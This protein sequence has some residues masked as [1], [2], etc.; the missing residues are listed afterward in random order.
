MKNPSATEVIAVFRSRVLWLAGLVVCL[1]GREEGPAFAQEAA[2]AFHLADGTS[3]PL[4]WDANRMIVRTTAE[5]SPSA[6]GEIARQ[7]LGRAMPLQTNSDDGRWFSLELGA[8][9]SREEWEARAAEWAADKTVAGV[10]PT[11]HDA[12]SG[13]RLT[14]TDEILVCRREG[15]T[16]EALSAVTAPLRLQLIER[17]RFDSRIVRL[18]AEDPSAPIRNPKSAIRNGQG[19]AALELANALF[20]SG[21]VEWAEPNF[22]IELRRAYFPNDP[23]FPQQWP[24]HNTGQT[25]GLPDADLD[26]AEAWDITRGSWGLTIAILDDGL[27]IAHPDLRGNVYVNTRE[28]PANGRDDDGNGYVDDVT[29]WDFYAN[30]NNPRPDGPEDWHSTPCAGMAAAIGDNGLGVTGVAPR[31]AILPCRI[32]GQFDST[33]SQIANAIHYASRTADILSLSW[34]A[35]PNNTISASLQN[36]AVEGRGGRG[37]LICAATGNEYQTTG[38]G[39]PANLSFVTA[40][41][42]STFRDVR[43]AYSNYAQG[44]G[45]FL[46]A[47]SSEPGALNGAYTLQAGGGYALFSGTSAATPEA[48]GVCALVLSVAPGLS[49]TQVADILARTADKIDPVVAGYDATGYS[50]AYGYGRVNAGRAVAEVAPDLSPAAFDFQPDVAARG[51][52]LALSGTVRNV[53]RGENASCWLEFWLSNSPTFATL[54]GLAC[55]SVRLPALAAGSEFRLEPVAANLLSSVADGFYRLGAVVDRLNEQIESNETNNVLSPSARILQVGGGSTN[56]DLRVEGF[57]FS[58]LEVTGG[59][60]IVLKG[61]VVN[62]GGQMS[63]PVWVEFWLSSKSNGG[64]LERVLCEWVGT[65]WLGPGEA[66]D[67]ATLSRTVFYPSQGM[68]SGRYRVGVVVDRPNG[69]VE[70]NENNNTVFRL[71]KWLT[72]GG[73]TEARAW[74]LYK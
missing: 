60:R 28:V 50:N 31:C 1:W 52:S 58:P 34:T 42:A 48:A 8:S 63:R 64:S 51:G 66:F 18:R 71:D 29:G 37:C 41:G 36:A 65:G 14:L 2:Y 25:G 6:V 3:V 27:D 21:A 67:L 56:V 39:Y 44:F 43:A 62:R 26:A 73:A 57:D 46:L 45:V 55:A 38:V 70:T 15:T 35:A 7:R 16:D 23:L 68:R 32:I 4:H 11:F 19:F 9:L 13:H 54:D 47:P 40:I 61:R 59:D 20:R 12:Q 74:E 49:R 72:V 22:R 30:D 5:T 10:F 33:I 17:C 69:Q 53:G 24:L